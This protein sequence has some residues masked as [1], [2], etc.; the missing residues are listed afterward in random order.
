MRGFF[1]IVANFREF[2]PHSSAAD[3]FV[4]QLNVRVISGISFG[5]QGIHLLDVDRRKRTG[6]LFT[7]NEEETAKDG[8]SMLLWKPTEAGLLE[9]GKASATKVLS[10]DKY[11]T[12]EVL[13][14]RCLEIHD[15]AADFI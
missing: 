8:E 9:Q 12:K 13:T 15:S 4:S 3:S 5:N 14:E 1:K 10:E 6:N 11:L 2:K 7:N